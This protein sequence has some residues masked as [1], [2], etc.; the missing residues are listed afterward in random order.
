MQT[1]MDKEEN[2]QTA[3][4]EIKIEPETLPVQPQVPIK[5]ENTQVSATQ[6]QA[7]QQA[8][9]K[10]P[11]KQGRDMEEA[12]AE[13]L[14][15]Q[16]LR[17]MNLAA[18][19]MRMDKEDPIEKQRQKAIIAQQLKAEHEKEKANRAKMQR[20]EKAKKVCEPFKISKW[21]LENID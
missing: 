19:K 13:R 21:K 16:K 18:T 3:T 10:T 20:E 1:E 15:T 14:E 2:G 6:A 17:A 4:R 11:Q 7:A 5:K 8:K 12:A 9:T